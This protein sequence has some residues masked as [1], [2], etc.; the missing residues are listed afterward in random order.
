MRTA[1][2]NNR[3]ASYYA[4]G[5]NLPLQDQYDIDAVVSHIYR[6]AEKE[7]M[8]ELEDKAHGTTSNY[9]H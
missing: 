6:V 2:D 8:D 3:S 5:P 9:H 1:K 4:F 7:K